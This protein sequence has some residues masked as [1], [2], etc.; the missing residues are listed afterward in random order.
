MERIKISIIMPIY[1]LENYL[2]KCLESVLNQTLKEI[3]VICIDDGST[4]NSLKILRK[5]KD[6]RIKIFTKENGGVSSA[7]NYGL[8]VA[9]GEYIG[10]VDGDDFI[11]VDMYQKL[12]RNAITNKSDIV[13]C[14]IKYIFSENNYKIFSE[15]FLGVKKIKTNKELFN[16][17]GYVW[18]KI[19]KKQ[20]I[21][22]IKF[23]ENIKW[24]E[25]QLFFTETLFKSDIIT[26]E[27]SI[28]YNYY[29]RQNSSTFVSNEKILDLIKSY[30]KIKDIL[31]ENKSYDIFKEIYLRNFLKI[32]LFIN[33]RNIKINEKKIQNEIQRVLS[34]EKKYILMEMKKN[35][36]TL[37]LNLKDFFK[38][39]ILL[40]NFDIFLKFI[41]K[42]KN[43][44]YSVKMINR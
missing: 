14:N 20:I 34:L 6:E 25:D 10:F 22:E 33:S 17:K 13:I 40:Y 7:R 24:G 1:N 23:D 18:N 41:N 42:L 32:L 15:N 44:W 29:Q 2:E 3:E 36:I 4:D 9:R 5:Y 31:L 38:W 8:K 28:S 11:E 43:R 27:N 39:K 16:I 35:N 37:K 12:Y 30:K 21:N 26:F 19:F